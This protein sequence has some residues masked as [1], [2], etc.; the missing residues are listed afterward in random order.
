MNN[1]I[2]LSITFLPVKSR[3]KNK[4]HVTDVATNPDSVNE[5]KKFV[6]YTASKKFV[7]KTFVSTL[8][9][10]PFFEILFIIV[11]L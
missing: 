9:D 11:T 4:V 2:Q 5:Y 3:Y 7:G 6:S 1:I 8:Y 10:F